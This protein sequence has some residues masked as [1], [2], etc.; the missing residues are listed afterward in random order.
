MT[1]AAVELTP[2]VV[3]VVV[4]S[5]VEVVAMAAAVFVT[6]ETWLA[7]VVTIAAKV[8][9]RSGGD[10]STEWFGPAMTPLTVELEAEGVVAESAMVVFLQLET[11]REEF[12]DERTVEIASAVVTFES[13]QVAPTWAMLVVNESKTEALSV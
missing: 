13:I 10:R 9:V 8:V 7:P 1:T 12:N 2:V 11:V 3:V 6:R 5:Q 4:V